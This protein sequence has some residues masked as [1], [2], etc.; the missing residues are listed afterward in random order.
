MKPFY[1]GSE[2]SRRSEQLD[3]KFGESIIS[4]SDSCYCGKC[5]RRVE[6]AERQTVCSQE[7]CGAVWKQ[8]ILMTTGNIIENAHLPIVCIDV[9]SRRPQRSS[10]DLFYALG[11][12]SIQTVIVTG[13]HL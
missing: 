4:D 7:N 5:R 9:I 3:Y 1:G 11:M 6:I 13:E 2:H 10:D 12:R 8:I